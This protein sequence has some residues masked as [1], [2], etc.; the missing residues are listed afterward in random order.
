VTLQTVLSFVSIIHRMAVMAVG[1]KWTSDPCVSRPGQRAGAVAAVQHPAVAAARD[2]QAAIEDSRPAYRRLAAG[3]ASA[4]EKLA[5][6]RVMLRKLIT[7]A[8]LVQQQRKA[9]QHQDLNPLWEVAELAS[10]S[11]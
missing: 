8:C 1:R 10:A 11:P 3:E 6:Q 4:G 2:L 9:L 5:L 7:V